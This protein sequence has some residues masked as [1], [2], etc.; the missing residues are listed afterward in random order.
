MAAEKRFWLLRRLSKAFTAGAWVVLGL[1]LVVTP[2]AVARAVLQHDR[3]SLIEWVQYGASGLLIFVNLIWLAQ[4]IQVVLAIEENT[5]H[6]GY[7][8][9]KLASLVQQ[10]RDRLPE[11]GEP[12]ERRGQGG[13]GSRSG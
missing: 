12:T 9:E 7:V 6:T 2:V 11:G 10:V 4:S 1:V 13:P 3:E 5:R 8:L